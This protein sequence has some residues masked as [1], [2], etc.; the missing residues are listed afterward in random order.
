M[1]LSPLGNKGSWE[2]HGLCDRFT[3]MNTPSY[4]DVEPA[5]AKTDDE[6]HTKSLK[7]GE[8]NK[9]FAAGKEHAT[10]AAEELKQAALL[11]A[12]EVRDVT[13]ER[14]NLY[15]DQVTGKYTDTRSRVEQLAKEDPI[16]TLAYAAG[17]GFVAGFLF[18]K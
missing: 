10:Q 11:K 16:K 3:D 14:A 17:I 4:P 15:R 13:T 9:Q 12:Q 1:T 7:A 5:A 2:R 8:A 18:R 6:S